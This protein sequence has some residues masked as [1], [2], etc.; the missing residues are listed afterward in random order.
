MLFETAPM[1]MI[2][3]SVLSEEDF[4]DDVLHAEENMQDNEELHMGS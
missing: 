4:T 2:A 3:Y 1:K